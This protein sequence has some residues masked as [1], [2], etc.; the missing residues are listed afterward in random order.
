[1]MLR[2]EITR[3]GFGPLQPTPADTKNAYEPFFA[4]LAKKLAADMKESRYMQC[5]KLVCAEAPA[6]RR[7]CP[8]YIE[9][10][11]RGEG[12]FRDDYDMRPGGGP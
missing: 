12:K 5:L 11:F 10:E 9:R 8:D 6:G 4:Y 3:F 7:E 2:G 1:M